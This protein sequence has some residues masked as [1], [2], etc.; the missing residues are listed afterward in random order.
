GRQPID[1][2]TALGVGD[3]PCGGD[4]AL[5]E[6]ALKRGIERSRF[7]LQHVGGLR[8]DEEQEA[9]AVARSRAQ[10]LEDDE[11]ERALEELD[12][13]GR[14]RRAGHD[15]SICRWPTYYA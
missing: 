9:V 12:A 7:H 10:R 14:G 8:A 2:H 5:A 4:G 13:R 11:V 15:A 1:A 3:A 6:Q